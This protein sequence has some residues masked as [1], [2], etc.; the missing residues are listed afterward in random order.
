MNQNSIG[1]SASLAERLREVY[2]TGKWI[3]NTN[4]QEQLLTTSFQQALMKVNQL[5]TIA[6]LIFHVNYYLEGLTEVLDGGA[7][8]ISDK[9]SFNMPPLHTEIEWEKMKSDFL[10]NA[11]KFADKVELITDHQLDLPFVKESYGTWHRNI[12][13]VME[14]SYYHLGQMVLIKKMVSQ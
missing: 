2:L 14:H 13:A 11:E 10:S 8:T 6:A 3:A 12:E 1:R 9:Q 5:N 4:Y 7:L